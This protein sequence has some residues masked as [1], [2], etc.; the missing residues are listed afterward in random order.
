V[1]GEEKVEGNGTNENGAKRVGR[2]QNKR[3][4]DK[5]RNEKENR[6]QLFESTK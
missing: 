2:G 4:C 6:K 5:W 3:K 1:E